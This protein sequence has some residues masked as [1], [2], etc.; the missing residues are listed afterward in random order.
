MKSNKVSS[1][2]EASYSDSDDEEYGMEV[3]D[4]KKK[5]KRKGKFVRQPHDEKRN[6][7]RIK[8]EKKGKEEWR[9]FKCGDPNH[10]ISDC[11]KHSFNNQK[12]FVG[13]CWSDSEEDDSKKDEICL[14]ELDNNEVR[15]KVKL[16]PDKWIKDSGRLRHMTSNKDLFSIYEGINGETTRIKESLNVRFD[17]SSSPKSSPIVD[18]D[19]SESQIIE[20]QIENVED[21]ENRPLNKEIVNIKESK[22]HLIETVIEPKN[23][24]EA[25]HNESWTMAMQEE[26]NQFVTNDVWS[27]VPPPDNKTIIGTKWVFKNKLDENDV[28]SRNKASLIAQ[29][30]NQQERIDFDETYASVARLE[31]IRILLAYA[32]AHDFKLFQKDVKSTF[33]NGFIKEEVYVS[34]PPGFVDFEKPNHVFKLKKALYGLKQAPKAWYD[35][36]KAF[37]LDHKYTMGL[38]FG[39]EYSK[40][41]KNPMSSETKLTR[42]ED[43]KSIDDTKYR[44]MIGLWYLKGTR[45]EPIV[46]ADSDH[47]RDYVDRKSTSDVCTFMG[48]CLTSWFSKKQTSL[49]ISTTEVEYVSAG[50]ACQQALWMKQALVD[51]DIKL[52]YIRIFCD[53]KGAIDLNISMSTAYHPETDGQ[54]ERT[55]QTLE[56]MLRACV[57]DFGKGWVKHL[58]LAE[59]SYN[60]SYHASIKAAPY[61]ALYGRKCRSPVCWAEVGEAQLTA[62]IDPETTEK[63]SPDQ[64][65]DASFA[66]STK[67][68]RRSETKADGVRGWGQSYAQGLALERGHTVRL[69]LPQ[70]LSRVYHTFHVSN[71]KKCYADEPLVMPLEGIHVD[72]K[73]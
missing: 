9:C 19:I 57:I 61:E 39:L 65:E 46:Y 27:L 70:E 14:M 53:N 58:P 4:F 62:G 36:L 49:A 3:R 22:G 25:I 56:D 42:D 37:L 18:D 50:K 15:L 5:F 34:Q 51:Y 47:A 21:K 66:R 12:A 71:L 48:C 6:F 10:F 64:A 43:E 67:E 13:G 55:I 41:I 40:P 26:L 16:E 28:V 32:C 24:K 45:I 72:D 68:L 30:Y 31:C 23:I 29:G 59:F 17:E 69:E 7:Q 73:L 44:G 54:S 11:P 1:H 8:E 2:E 60:N 52:D 38:K 63:N 35:R 20:N 33:L